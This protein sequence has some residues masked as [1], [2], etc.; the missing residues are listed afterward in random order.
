MD[1]AEVKPDVTGMDM[2]STRNPVGMVSSL[3]YEIMMKVVE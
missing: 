2:K 3:R 1:V